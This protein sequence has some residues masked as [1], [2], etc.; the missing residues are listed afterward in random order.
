MKL[1]LL[2]VLAA[3]L[4][5]DVVAQNSQ[6]RV[7]QLIAMNLGELLKVDIATGSPVDIDKAPAVATVITARQISAMGA[8]NLLEVLDSVPGMHVGRN[9]QNIAPRFAF[10]GIITTYTPQALVLVNGVSLKSVVRGDSHT[11]WGE[12]PVQAISRIEIL[13]GP[14]SALY[15]ADAFSGVINIIT[16]TADDIENSQAGAMVGSFDTYNLWLN[17]GSQWRDW[18]FGLNVEL[19]KTDGYEEL[20]ESDGQTNLDALGDMLFASGAL[21]F[22]PVDASLAPASVSMGF[23]TLH[24]WTTAENQHLSLMLGIQDLRDNGV[25]QGATEVLDLVGRTASYKHLFKAALKPVS[26]N[27]STDFS[28]E[29]HYYRSSQEIE[30]RMMLFP[31]GAFFGAFPDGFIGNPGGKRTP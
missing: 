17:H 22:D 6:S 31:P 25:G 21:P 20:I 24:L 2:V 18:K 9:S 28:A 26:V 11:V 16:K 1:K 23:Q 3:L 19:L 12:F 30:N 10:R 5:G 13:R 4:G 27:Q 7:Q 29:L 8:R 15:G 14:G